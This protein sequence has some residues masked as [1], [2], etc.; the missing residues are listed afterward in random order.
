[1]EDGSSGGARLERCPD[2]F[3]NPLND[4]SCYAIGSDL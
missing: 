4:L 2:L 3:F 1:M